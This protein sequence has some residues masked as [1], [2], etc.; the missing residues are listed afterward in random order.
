MSPNGTKPPPGA[1]HFLLLLLTVWAVVVLVTGGPGWLPRGVGRYD[2]QRLFQVVILALGILLIILPPATRR[3]TGAVWALQGRLARFLAA[4]FLALGLVSALR[5]ANPEAALAEWGLWAALGIFTLGAAAALTRLGE[6]SNAVLLTGLT[7]G[8]VLYLGDFYAAYSWAT[9]ARGVPIIW[10]SPFFGF[11]NVR[12]FNQVQSWSLP[13]VSVA[14]VWAWRSNRSLGVLLV[15]MAAAWWALLFATGSRGAG[16]AQV[17]G[18][19]TAILFLGR[20]AWHW[21]AWHLGLALA[22]SVLYFSLFFSHSPGAGRAIEKS[23]QIDSARLTLWSQALDLFGEAPFLGVGPMHFAASET[24]RR[25]AHPHN[26]P[27]QLA[28]EWGLP[29][30][31]AFMGLIGWG[32]WRWL[33]SRRREVAQDLGGNGRALL[34]A[35][36][37]ASLL[38]GIA[39]AMVSGIV[40]T[41]ASQFLG[42]FLAAW[43]WAI[44]VRGQALHAAHHKGPHHG[45]WLI[46]VG[47]LAL[48]SFLVPVASQVPHLNAN[49]Q[50]YSKEGGKFHPRF[51]IQGRLEYPPWSQ[52]PD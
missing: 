19:L 9:W 34:V 16:L 27:L 25:L 22:G 47:G 39:H 40:V 33:L 1:A 26:A 51:W 36:L 3:Q 52:P 24:F 43:A 5:A 12:F 28:A 8:V 38:A 30:A 41:P 20:M 32:L 42:S 15:L 11:A 44:H 37:A 49:H 17:L 35:G 31:L 2:D 13:L 48:A 14:A 29:A 21:A 10:D 4:T 18:A 6:T 46:P 7:T 23:A 45:L 50:T